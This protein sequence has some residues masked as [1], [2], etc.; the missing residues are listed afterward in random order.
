MEIEE[1]RRY[2]LRAGETKE[3]KIAGEKTV[4]LVLV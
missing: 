1:E 4:S 2:E 3:K